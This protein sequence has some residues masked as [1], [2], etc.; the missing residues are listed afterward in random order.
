[1]ECDRL[2]D[3]IALV[4]NAQDGDALRHRS[5]SGLVHAC[6]RRGILRSLILHRFLLLPAPARGKRQRE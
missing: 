5:H 1:M 6:G 2:G 4:E 3:S